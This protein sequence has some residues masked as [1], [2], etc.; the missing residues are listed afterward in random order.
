MPLPEKV[1]KER[2]AKRN[3]GEELLQAVRDIKAGKGK[4]VAKVE[5]TAV[6]ARL[7]KLVIAAQLHPHFGLFAQ[8]HRATD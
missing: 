3:V 1:L 6:K 4:I 7:H 5:T 2:D 8:K